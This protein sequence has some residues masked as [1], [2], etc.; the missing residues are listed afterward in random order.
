MQA[1]PPP[2]RDAASAFRIE[3]SPPACLLAEKTPRLVACLQPRSQRAALRVLFRAEG[4]GAWYASPLRSDV[5][6]YT[7]LLPRPSRA[8]GRVV[9]V[10]EAEGPEGRTRTPEFAV[11][12]AR[13]PAACAGRPRLWQPAAAPRG[14]RLRGAPDARWVRRC[15]TSGP[16]FDCVGPAATT[17]AQRHDETRNPSLTRDLDHCARRRLAQPPPSVPPAPAT[18][19]GGGHGLRNTAIVVGTAAAGGSRRSAH[20]QGR[21]RRRLTSDG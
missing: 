2:A 12:V 17:G 1:P 3:H 13:T 8:L 20:S 4:D 9:Y 11:P 7:G 19:E 21:G 18:R 16:T 5:P 15:P 14:R 6:C 10:I